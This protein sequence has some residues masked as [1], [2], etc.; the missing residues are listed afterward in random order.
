METANNLSWELWSLSER[1]ERGGPCWLVKLSWMGTQRVQM[2]RVLPWLVRWVRHAGPRWLLSCLGCSGQLS[3]RY[4]I[5]IY[6]SS[7]PGQAVVQ[8]RLFL[9]VWSPALILQWFQSSEHCGAKKTAF[10]YFRTILAK[11]REIE[12]SEERRS[13]MMRIVWR[14]RFII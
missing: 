13:S 10:C 9:N 1:P 5:S 3:T 7:S 11:L 6:V 14:F 8:G 2:K 12:D 4:T